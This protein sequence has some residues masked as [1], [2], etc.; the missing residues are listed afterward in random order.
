MAVAPAGAGSGNTMSEDD[1]KIVPFWGTSPLLGEDELFSELAERKGTSLF[2]GKYTL[3][4]VLAVLTRKSFIKEARK[5]GLWPLDYELD[6][7]QFPLQRFQI[8]LRD[9]KPE[10]LIVD[11]KIREGAL[12]PPASIRTD[13]AAAGFKSLVLEWLTLQ[14]PAAEFGEKRGSLPGQLHPGL[15]MSRKVMDVFVYIGKLIRTDAI[16]AFPAFYHNAVLFSR[17]FR[18]LNPEKEGEIQAIRRSFSRFSIRQ[19]AWAIYLNCLIRDDGTPYEWRAE[20]QVYP[21]HKDLRDYFDSKAYRERVKESL[22]RERFTL[23]A[24]TFSRKFQAD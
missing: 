15:G 17:Y 12:S 18:F 7:T 2:L 3:T 4:E 24:E 8:F 13:A 5:R 21:I 23:D 20:E 19:L 22:G 6:S 1:S 14:N 16:L 9:K 10:N 11:L